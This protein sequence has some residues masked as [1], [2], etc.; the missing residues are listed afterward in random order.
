MPRRPMRPCPFP[1]CHLLVRG[2]SR[3][4]VHGKDRRPS[5]HKRGYGKP[6]QVIRD[7]YLATY[8]RCEREDCDEASTDCD[9]IVPRRKGGTDDDSNL[10]AMCHSHHSHKTAVEDGGFGRAVS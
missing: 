2:G 7:A 9:H 10:M 1:G 6:W 5:A 8:P 4:P 3:C